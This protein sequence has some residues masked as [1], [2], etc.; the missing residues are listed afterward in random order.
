MPQKAAVQA[1]KIGDVFGW[2]PVARHAGG[3]YSVYDSF[4]NARQR[5][6]PRLV[7]SHINDR[8]ALLAIDLEDGASPAYQLIDIQGH[9]F[10]VSFSSF[11]F[12]TPIDKEGS[13]K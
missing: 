8:F 1:M 7:N 9:V 12:L 11:L 10:F 4:Q 6:N 2:H 3:M 5:L 13:D